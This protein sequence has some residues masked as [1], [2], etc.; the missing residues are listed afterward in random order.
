MLN[1]LMTKATLRRV[2][3]RNI[4]LGL[5]CIAMLGLSRHVEAAQP[6][7]ALIE[8]ISETTIAGIELLDYVSPGQVIQLGT[9]GTIILAYLESCV[10][11]TII[12]GEVTVGTHSSQ[13]KGG[14]VKREKPQCSSATLSDSRTLDIA[15]ATF[16]S[17]P[18]DK[19]SAE[20]RRTAIYSLSPIFEIGDY[21]T[22]ILRRIDQPG[23]RYEIVVSPSSLVKTRFYDFTVANG[24]LRAGGRYEVSLGAHQLIFEVDESASADGPLLSRL[25]RLTPSVKTTEG[26]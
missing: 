2:G 11:E 9:S 8:S 10:R 21:G 25:V 23:E 1:A 4:R 20:Y 16:R 19:G 3:E 18:T 7:S 24:R 14:K 12:G 15:G 5:I 13:V 22:M 17:R 6:P 26:R